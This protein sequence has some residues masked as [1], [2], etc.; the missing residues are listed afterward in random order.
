MLVKVAFLFLLA[1]IVIAV[2]GRHRLLGRRSAFCS[3]CGRAHVGN[4]PC[5]C[6]KGRR[7]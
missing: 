1:M 6:G 2:L 3:D 4:Q 7:P 5:I